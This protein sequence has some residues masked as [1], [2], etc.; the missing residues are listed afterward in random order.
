MIIHILQRFCD[1]AW[2]HLFGNQWLTDWLKET[3]WDC[4]ILITF[5]LSRVTLRTL[6]WDQSDCHYFSSIFC[7]KEIQFGL[8]FHP[9]NPYLQLELWIWIAILR[10][11]RREG[12]NNLCGGR[13]LPIWTPEQRRIHHA[14]GEADEVKSIKS[15]ISHFLSSPALDSTCHRRLRFVFQTSCPLEHLPSYT[16]KLWPVCSWLPL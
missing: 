13:L 2:G 10:V 4:F 5:W 14:A 1:F 7:A 11:E 12:S 3:T 6:V 9:V 15:L 8:I 16:S